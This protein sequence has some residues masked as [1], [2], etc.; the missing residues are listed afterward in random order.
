MRT[1][2]KCLTEITATLKAI[3]LKVY[4]AS[5][6]A[7]NR[8]RDFGLWL[9]AAHRKENGVPYGRNDH[10]KLTGRYDVLAGIPATY[11]A[12]NLIKAYPDTKIILVSG[13]EAG[14]TKCPLSL[15]VLSRFDPKYLGK[16]ATFMDAGFSVTPSPKRPVSST[17]LVAAPEVVA[18]AQLVFRQVRTDVATVLPILIIAI[19]AGLGTYLSAILLALP[20]EE[21]IFLGLY[22]CFTF[23]DFV[24]WSKDHTLKNVAIISAEKS[25]PKLVLRVSAPPKAVQNAP[26]VVQESPAPIK[27]PLS[28]IQPKK[29]PWA[30]F[31]EEIFKD[32]F[33]TFVAHEVKAMENKNNKVQFHEKNSQDYGD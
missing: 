15:R 22:A 30:N 7:T 28:H 4:D 25:E 20:P 12:S 2:L 16:I 13:L 1:P 17:K 33:R 29:D 10:D 6:A 32:D 26:A 18:Q 14:I 21:A 31:Q 5:A 3:G 8:E 9:E 27:N 23:M 11:F 24:S 19:C